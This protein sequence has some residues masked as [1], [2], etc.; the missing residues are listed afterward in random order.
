MDPMGYEDDWRERSVRIQFHHQKTMEALQS[1]WVA[2]KE[3]SNYRTCIRALHNHAL[4]QC[5]FQDTG[6]V[7]IKASG[8]AGESCHV[9][10]ELDGKIFPIEVE[11]SAPHLPVAGCKCTGYEDHQTG[12]CLCRYESAFEDEFEQQQGAR[13]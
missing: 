2:S 1:A 10:R 7:T 4:Q 12:F 3:D 8:R 5:K 6:Y 11:E 13:A 9:C